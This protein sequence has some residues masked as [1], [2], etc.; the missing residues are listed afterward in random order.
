MTAHVE[1]E[2]STAIVVPARNAATGWVNS[3]LAS[4]TDEDRPVLCQTL[5][6]EWYDQGLHIVGSDG[7]ALF[8]SWVPC[9]PE[10]KWPPHRYEPERQVIVMDTE[11]FGLAFMRS[12]LRVTNDEAH[13]HEEL[14]VTTAPADEG[15]TLSLGAAFTNER[16]IL[17]AC[18]QRIDLRL[19]EDKYPNWRGL[20]LGIDDDD[21]V[22]GFVIASRL[23]AMVG[24]LKGVAAIDVKLHGDRKMIAFEADGD[25][26]VRGLLAAMEKRV[27]P[28]EREVK[29]TAT[30]RE[31][32]DS[33]E[34]IRANTSVSVNGGEK[35]SMDEFERRAMSGEIDIT[36]RGR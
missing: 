25:A 4:G 24:K 21:R 36:G 7:T 17:R 35:M 29:V 6:L 28:P 12:L 22:A 27:P 9:E 14:T 10:T 8:R 19:R 26:P 20:Q 13:A 23:F 32:G 33:D 15:A 16:L 30:Q 34:D 31:L 2:E 1:S 11:G 18:G 5:S 3:F